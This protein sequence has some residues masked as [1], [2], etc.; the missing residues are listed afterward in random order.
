[1]VIFL[2][3][4]ELQPI[5]EQ[6][7]RRQAMISMIQFDPE[8]RDIVVLSADKSDFD[9]KDVIGGAYQVSVHTVCGRR[10]RIASDALGRVKV[11]PPSV[12]SKEGS[13]LLTG[14]I[15]VLSREGEE[16]GLSDQEI[17]DITQRGFW[18]ARMHGIS[19]PG[20]MVLR[21]ED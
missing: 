15:V 8:V 19:E 3:E 17:S 12:L 2:D 21:T 20:R 13:V 1:M 14:P 11:M 16:L 9:L 5:E 7:E 18:E 4:K 10:Y 6:M